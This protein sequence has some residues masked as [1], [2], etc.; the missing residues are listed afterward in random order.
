MR[1]G[2][3]KRHTRTT[4]QIPDW[5]TNLAAS[6]LATSHR[7]TRNASRMLKFSTEA[8]TTILCDPTFFIDGV[9]ASVTL[10][11]STRT[12]AIGRTS[13]VGDA[14]VR[15]RDGSTLTLTGAH[16]FPGGRKNVVSTQQV[17]ARG[18]IDFSSDGMRLASGA[19]LPFDAGY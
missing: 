16:L 15:L 2:G 4:S 9:D 6:E 3:A 18:T 19:L 13:G 7:N 12:G 8:T 11:A 5:R 10:E 17:A 1:P 14:I